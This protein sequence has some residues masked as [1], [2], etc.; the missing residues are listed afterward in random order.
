MV[1]EQQPL[2]LDKEI[3][4]RNVL[5][6]ALKTAGVL[7][8]APLLTGCGE[9]NEK[10]TVVYQTSA[11]FQAPYDIGRKLGTFD[12]Y[13]LNIEE[14][15]N[16]KQQNLYEGVIFGTPFVNL[17]ACINT[18]PGRDHPVMIGV[19]QNRAP[20]VLVSRKDPADIKK[21]VVGG[22]GPGSDPH[23]QAALGMWHLG[24]DP[25]KII[26]VANVT[27]TTPWPQTSRLDH[28][29]RESGEVDA[30]WVPTPWLDVYPNIRTPK[31]GTNVIWN[32]SSEPSVFYAIVS[33]L[34]YIKS[35]MSKIKELISAVGETRIWMNSHQTETVGLMEEVIASKKFKLP[36]GFVS[37]SMKRYFDT[38]QDPVTT[39][40]LEL[41]AKSLDLFGAMFPQDKAKFE[42]YRSRL[43]E[44]VMVLS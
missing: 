43:S 37:A 19:I 28:I 26:A 22:G 31:A 34:N 17:H 2:G 10:L 35:H 16:A 42:A 39:P 11:A 25:S 33:Q 24:Q 20:S 38:N 13:H 8:V 3:S 12:K 44:S 41:I 21:I 40:K 1:P 30:A 7:G 14:L 36:E 23:H 4:R 15:D 18:E 9:D 5:A 6:L 27:E 32:S 29:D